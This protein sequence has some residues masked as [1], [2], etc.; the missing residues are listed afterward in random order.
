MP[1]RVMRFADKCRCLPL[2]SYWDEVRKLTR[3]V[4]SDHYIGMYQS[5]AESIYTTRVGKEG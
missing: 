3:R 1:K 5:I 4:T 2:D